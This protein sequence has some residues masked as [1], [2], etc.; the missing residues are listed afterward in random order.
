MVT[1]SVESPDLEKAENY[2]NPDV[3]PV[4]YQPTEI[5]HTPHVSTDFGHAA[6]Q[7]MQAPSKESRHKAVPPTPISYDVGYAVEP[8]INAG[9]VAAV[10]NTQETAARVYNAFTTVVNPGSGAYPGDPVLLLG[11]DPNR[12]KVSISV[13]GAPVLVG[14]LHAVSAGAGFLLP[15]GGV[16]FEPEVQSEI[17]ACIPVGGVASAQ[18][19][20]W[21]E[22]NL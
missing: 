13:T 7:A 6:N 3:I 1:N 19:G 16:L 18:V 15:A 9:S 5:P 22:R 11:D 8:E 17:Y 14:P 4:G 10:V 20:V 2:P 12:Q 21:V